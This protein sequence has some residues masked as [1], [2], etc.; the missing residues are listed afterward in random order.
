MI[1]FN[2]GLIGAKRTIS[3]GASIP[4]VWT[5]NEQCLS[6]RDGI[7]A[8]NFVPVQ[9]F[10]DDGAD[11][12]VNGVIPLTGG[13]PFWID[14]VPANAD[15]DYSGSNSFNRVM[16]G[17]LSTSVYWTGDQYGQGTVTQIRLELVPRIVTP[18][19]IST[20]RIY[21]RN[22]STSASYVSYDAQLL[23][24]NKTA[25]SGT[26][27]SLDAPAQW[28]DIPVLGDPY[29]LEISCSSGSA[30]RLYLYAI[31]VNGSILIDT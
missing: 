22:Y 29:Y 14:V 20:V 16:D 31:E 26:S 13:N 11:D 3:I 10:M 12:A 24:S 27:V 6:K 23:D 25:I 21:G 8:S 1:G 19:E 17:S 2:G 4:G 7:W 30:R 18:G 28:H 9:N 15:L 5:V